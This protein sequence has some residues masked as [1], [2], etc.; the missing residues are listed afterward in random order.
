MAPMNANQ[1]AR[2]T[3]DCDGII[4]HQTYARGII[5]KYLQNYFQNTSIKINLLSI[6]KIA[7][8]RVSLG[9]AVSREPNHLTVRRKN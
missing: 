1:I 3:N 2:N 5:L 8:L 7:K 4:S 6:A 9:L